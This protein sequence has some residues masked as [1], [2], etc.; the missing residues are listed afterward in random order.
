MFGVYQDDYADGSFKIGRSSFKLEITTEGLWELLTKSKRGH[1]S[2]QRTNKQILL[3]SNA[4]GFIVPQA[5]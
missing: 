4:H 1:S 5:R 3:Q 2:R